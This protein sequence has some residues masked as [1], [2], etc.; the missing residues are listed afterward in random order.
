MCVGYT[1]IK[2]KMT[3]TRKKSSKKCRYDSNEEGLVFMH[4]CKWTYML[5]QYIVRIHTMQ[6]DLFTCLSLART[7]TRIL[8]PTHPHT[9]T[10]ETFLF[11][12]TPESKA[13]IDQWA[14][15]RA[16]KQTVIDKMDK[17]RKVYYLRHASLAADMLY[18]SL[19]RPPSVL[20]TTLL[21]SLRPHIY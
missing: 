2:T 4:T 14:I 12:S 7:H 1:L 11:L 18:T 6:K 3:Q 8:L 21:S 15:E 17:K 20:C 19:L 10:Q 9:H 16:K 13:M 5:A